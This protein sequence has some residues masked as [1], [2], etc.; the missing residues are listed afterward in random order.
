[1][2]LFYPFYS[3]FMCY[4]VTTTHCRQRY[5][6]VTTQNRYTNR[7]ISSYWRK[8]SSISVFRYIPLKRWQVFLFLCFCRIS[9]LMNFNSSFVSFHPSTTSQTYNRDNKVFWTNIVS[10]FDEWQKREL[11]ILPEYILF[12]LETTHNW[13]S[14]NVRLV[15]I[16]GGCILKYNIVFMLLNILLVME[17]NVFTKMYTY[18]KHTTQLVTL[19]YI[20]WKKKQNEI[21]SMWCGKKL[22]IFI[23]LF[24]VEDA[25]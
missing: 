16:Y 22:H 4:T 21:D 2:C 15:K 17:T 25:V 8:H 24:V 11:L 14:H 23:S 12:T 18:T 20:I 7:L 9:I 1:M 5:R 6:W 3:Y 19:T 13:K 10:H